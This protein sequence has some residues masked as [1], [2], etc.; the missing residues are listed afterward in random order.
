M[1]IGLIAVKLVLGL[2]AI[3]SGWRGYYR[4]EDQRARPQAAAFFWRFAPHD[5]RIDKLIAFDSRNFD[6]HFL[7]D[8]DLFGYPPYS[9]KRREIEFPLDVKWTGNIQL[10]RETWIA[11]AAS[12]TGRLTLVIDGGIRAETETGSLEEIARVSGG[13]HAIRISYLKPAN[14]APWVYV[15][16]TDAR[17]GAPIPVT[18]RP[19][20]VHAPKR[21]A[22]ITTVTTAVGLALVFVVLAT[23]YVRAGPHPPL[24]EMLAPAAGLAVAGLVTIWTAQLAVRTI[25]TTAFIPAGADPLLYASDARHI[26]LGDPLLLKG[27]LPGQASPFYFY[28]FYPYVLAFMHA[29]VGDDLSTIFLLNGLALAL[30]PLLFW[31]LG[32][33]HLDSGPAV[34]GFAALLVFIAVYGWPV[35]AFDLPA[36]TDIV[37]LAVVFGALIALAHAYQNPR[38]LSLVASGL[39]I[40]LGA[41]TRPS[42]LTLVGLA[43]IGLCFARWHRTSRRSLLV[44][45]AWLLAGAFL[46]LLPF[47][48]RNLIA[49][50]RFVLLVNSWIQL[51]YFLIPPEVTTKP[52]GIPEFG[53][54]VRMARDIALRDPVGTFW[55]EIR[56]VLFTFGLTSFGPRGLMTTSALIVLPPLFL[57]SVWLRRIPAALAVALVTFA[58]SHVVAMVL[59]APWTFGVKSILPL[60]GAFL[61]GAIYLLDEARRA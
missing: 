25:G 8:V 18:A 9:T 33:H 21:F 2:L 22:R 51:P 13:A 10:Q 24:R 1:L 4:F 29:I 11:I 14:V 20:S 23:C 59:A 46:G 45:C 6:L 47:T 36:F 27:L 28:P 39:L 57:L 42:M 56:K 17:T 55:V 34:I 61:F 49:A 31:R 60:H 35:A 16:L 12:A 7:N 32:W 52:G 53:E 26:A 43:P 41:A 3:P 19:T 44:A 50:G 58:I 30:L 48:L 38:P 15:T 54:A 37:F 5:F 40:G